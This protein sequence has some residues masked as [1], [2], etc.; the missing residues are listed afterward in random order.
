[1]T[2]NKDWDEEKWTADPVAVQLKMVSSEPPF[3]VLTTTFSFSGP[4]G[5]PR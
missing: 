3:P 2:I 4:I 1:M 5:D